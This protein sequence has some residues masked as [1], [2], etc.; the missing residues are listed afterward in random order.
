MDDAKVEAIQNW[1]V[2][3]KKKQLQS[4]LGFANFYRRFIK[5]YSIVV[6]PLTKLIGSKSDFIWETP[7][8]EAFENL[9]VAFTT[10][11]VLRHYDVSR[12][13]QI[14]CDSSTYGFGSIVSQEY[15]DGWHPI[16]FI[17]KQYLPSETRWP[18]YDQELYA[19]K[20]TL[21]SYRHF[22]IPSPFQTIIY[23]DHRKMMV[24][25]DSLSRKAEFEAAYT[26]ARVQAMKECEDGSIMMNSIELVGIDNSD[27]IKKLQQHTIDSKLYSD[28]KNKEKRTHKFV[29]KDKVLWFEGK[30]VLP[31]KALRSQVL[32][33]RHNSLL[34]GHYGFEK[35]LDLV[36]RDYYWDGMRKDVKIF[37]INCLT[38]NRIKAS[39]S[40]PYGLIQPQ[41]IPDNYWDSVNIDFI[42]DLPPS[43]GFD[44]IM[45]VKDRL[46]KQAH[47]I[48]VN[49]AIDTEK[50][51][52]LYMD[53]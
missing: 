26:P 45:V 50:T 31:S 37:C 10:A 49:K 46:S 15:E 25:P 40:K 29:L 7:Q 23:S 38:C 20:Y 27:F 19:I 30:I 47:F 52:E 41:S 24:Q 36:S 3:Q 14:E 22:I 28:Y 51:A 48:P 1:K 13:I 4:F 6:K 9:K 39:R 53:N 33:Q 43:R 34:G 5:C 21:M 17:S 8:Q 44:A 2:P 35:T 12:P 18:T 16:G 11:P 42:T 32:E